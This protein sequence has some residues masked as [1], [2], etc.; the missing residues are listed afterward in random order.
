MWYIF[1][2]MGVCDMSKTLGGYV[3]HLQ[4]KSWEIKFALNCELLIAGMCLLIV[5]LLLLRHDCFALL[6]QAN[7]VASAPSLE[8]CLQR[9]EDVLQSCEQIANNTY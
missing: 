3:I 8:P 5:W 7:H 6:K 4:D 1:K 9:L 2:K